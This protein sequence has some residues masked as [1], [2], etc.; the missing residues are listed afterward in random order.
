MQIGCQKKYSLHPFQMMTDFK[1]DK[2]DLN[3][4][5]KFTKDIVPTKHKRVCAE[6]SSSNIKISKRPSPEVNHQ[7]INR[8]Q[9]SQYGIIET[10][11]PKQNLLNNNMDRSTEHKIRKGEYKIDAV[12]DM[13][14]MNVES[15]FYAFSQFIQNS[16]ASHH[17]M[18]LVITGKGKGILK[19]ESKN[20]VQDKKFSNH[21]L[22]SFKAHPKH[23][24][25]GA[26]YI[27]LRRIRI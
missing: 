5:S 6:P 8:P 10:I 22:R 11:I 25:E 24:G 17:R 23:G 13:H 2:N 15:A 3:I 26:M 7:Y 21:I 4:W 1:P 27:L 19:R 18:L 14:G 9:S 20:W 16:I 12:L